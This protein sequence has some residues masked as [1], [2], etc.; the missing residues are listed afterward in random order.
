MIN[1]IAIVTGG[2]RGLGKNTVLH[3]SEK[4]IDTIFT[5][6]ERAAEAEA[7]VR[8]VEKKGGKSVALQLDASKIGSFP[9]FAQTVKETLAKK[10][11]VQKFDF[12]VNNAGIGMTV[13][14]VE[15]TEE[16]F[17]SLVNV[18]FKGVYFLT[19]KLLPLVNDGGRIIN[20]SSGTTRTTIPGYSVYAPAKSAI[21]TLTRY[22]AK[23]LG[24]RQITVNVVA[25]GAVET[26]FNGG[27]VRDNKEFN[28]RIAAMTPLGR[29]GLPDD[30]GPVIATMC[31]DDMRWINGER[32][33]VSGGQGI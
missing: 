29:V 19:Q 17:D 5:Y 13:P 18:H 25:P 21:E 9:A 20:V 14:F 30:I 26:D 8:E 6:R 2:S 32:I 11:N 15:M 22:L 1:K 3:M 4:G 23:E 12:L 27:R 28:A 10:W 24:P 31:L 33:E 7:V 16:Q